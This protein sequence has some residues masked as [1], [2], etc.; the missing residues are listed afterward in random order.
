M[1]RWPAVPDLPWQPTESLQV[2]AAARSRN[3]EASEKRTF[4]LQLAR[5]MGW[6]TVL[7]VDDDTTD[8][9]AADVRQA[10]GALGA[11]PASTFRMTQFADHSVVYHAAGAVGANLDV[12]LGGALV[13]RVDPGVPFF[14]PIYNEDWLFCHDWLARRQV[15][16]AGNL[17]QAEF[18]PFADPERA[19]QEEF[20]DLLGEGLLARLHRRERLLD[21]DLP[22]WRGVLRNRA[23]WLDAIEQA[24]PVARTDL[25]GRLAMAACLAA[26][27]A[28]LGRI[29]AGTLHEFVRAWRHDLQDWRRHLATLKPQLSTEPEAK[30]LRTALTTLG[31]GQHHLPRDSGFWAQVR[32][33]EQVGQVGQSSLPCPPP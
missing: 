7:F 1:V 22:F 6:R 29:D 33:V 20:G 9:L 18:D 8:L 24:L 3:L 19:R 25:A 15:R 31:L 26:A 5:L 12:L 10:V 23:L 32:Q 14:P 11:L 13:V 16:Y 30:R 2:A 17:T 28:E 21:V 27:R 4:G